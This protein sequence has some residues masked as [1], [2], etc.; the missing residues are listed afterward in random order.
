MNVNPAFVAITGAENRDVLL[1]GSIQAL[2]SD[3]KPKGKTEHKD[4]EETPRTAAQ[5]RLDMIKRGTDAS[6]RKED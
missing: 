3:A 6:K 5:A 2:H 1:S 4:V